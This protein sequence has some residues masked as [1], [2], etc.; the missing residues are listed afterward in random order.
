MS[1]VAR[2]T[3]HTMV[4]R[5][6]A[7]RLTEAKQQVPHF[8]AKVTCRLDALLAMRKRI[9]AGDHANKVSVNDLVVR[10][11]A[12]AMQDTP[13]ANVAWAEK[14][15][16]HFDVVDVAV[17]VATPRGLMTPILRNVAVKSPQDIAREIKDLSARARDGK[18]RP[19]EYLGGTVTVSNL[20]MFGV[21]EFSA[22]LNPPQS[23]IFAVGAAE[24]RPVVIDGALGVATMMTCVLSVDHRAVDGAIAGKLLAAFRGYIE[25]PHRLLVTTGAIAAPL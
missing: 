5:T 11:V 22:I 8:Y 2:E 21:E 3:P 10:A 7:R 25:E 23:V 18:L 13:E 14:T 9:N 17:A 16:H 6:I 4:R 20:G 15:M 19:E 24:P 12:M 1:V